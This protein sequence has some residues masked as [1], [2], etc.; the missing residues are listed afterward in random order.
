MKLAQLSTTELIAQLQDD[1]D[2]EELDTESEPQSAANANQE[3]AGDSATPTSSDIMISPGPGGLIVTSQ[4][5]EALD[6]FQTLFE[7]LSNQGGSQPPYH[8][9]YLKHLTA[10][11]ARD[12]A[13]QSVCP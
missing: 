5:E 12:F 8:L 10:D 2:D 9:F 1:A 4:D 6:A 11:A 13:Y 3:S 7:A